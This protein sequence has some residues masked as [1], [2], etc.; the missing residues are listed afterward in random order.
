MERARRGLISAVAVALVVTGA[1]GTSKRDPRGARAQ[2][3]TAEREERAGDLHEADRLYRLALNDAEMREPAS[4]AL[5]HLHGRRGWSLPTDH[6]EILTLL[7]ELG[8]GFEVTE[9][10]HFVVLSD[11][12]ADWTARRTAVLER[13]RHQYFR[14]TDRLGMPVY[15]HAKKLVCVLINDYERYR[16]FARRSDGLAAAWVAGYYS[17]RT[18]RAVFF[19]DETSQSY[20]AAVNSLATYEQRVSDWR[21]E[22]LEA[23]REGN[24]R[25]ARQ[26]EAAAVNLATKIETER[27]RLAREVS[28]ASTAKAIHETIHLL[29][30]N[31]GLQSRHSVYPFWFSE[32]LATSFET[33][34]PDIAFGPDH[35]TPNRDE[36]IE[37]LIEQA[38][39]IDIARL[40]S[41]IEA[42][43]HRADAGRLYTESYALFAYLFRY[44]REGLA[45]YARDLVTPRSLSRTDLTDMFEQHFGRPDLI[46]R[47][48]TARR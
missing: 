24:A 10:R 45:A 37:S 3:A 16:D 36:A 18:N 17:T 19:N 42:P 39:A 28:E 2:M 44:D 20:V 22:S 8:P 30:F 12:D 41:I 21:R 47:R 9:T 5:R 31:T 15:P 48:L 35:P 46:G 40:V 26:L 29:A 43:E 33:H 25:A 38:H 11:C 7:E 14:V 4:E 34:S 23:R 6:D 1:L 13:A 32:G 27:D